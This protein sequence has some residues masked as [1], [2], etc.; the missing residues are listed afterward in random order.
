M[1]RNRP[2]IVIDNLAKFQLKEAYEFIRL[3][4][5]KNAEKVKSE[6][7]AAIQK[8]SDHPERYHP[9][10]YRL[11]NDGAYRAFELYKYRV[12]FHVS[13]TQ[14]TIIKICHTSMEP[15]PY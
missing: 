14:I 10:Q 2:V 1:V 5:P 6:I 3:D 8:L 15:K 9:D 12:S 11:N 4:S 7:L 13:Q